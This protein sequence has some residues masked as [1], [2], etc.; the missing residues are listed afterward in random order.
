MKRIEKLE[1][2]EH[3]FNEVMKHHMC[4]NYISMSDID[5]LEYSDI[6]WEVDYNRYNF[7]AHT[8]FGV[9]KFKYDFDFNFDANL[10]A[11]VEELQEFLYSK[12]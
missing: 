12:V 5:G 6:E 4:G 3:G 8:E 9:F 1:V 2:L 11:F 7:I 10:E